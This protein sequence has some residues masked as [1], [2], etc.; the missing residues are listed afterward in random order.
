[1]PSLYLIVMCDAHLIDDKEVDKGQSVIWNIVATKVKGIFLE[2]ICPKPC[3][4]F[5]ATHESTQVSKEDEVGKRRE[6]REQI[7]VVYPP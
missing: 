6:Q 5:W 2:A 3:E 4:C 7:A 1:M